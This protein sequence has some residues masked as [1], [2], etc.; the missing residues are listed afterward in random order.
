MKNGA[1]RWR[2]WLQ[3]GHKWAGFS[4][5][6]LFVLLGLTGSVL[7]FYQDLDDGFRDSGQA[8]LLVVPPDRIVAALRAAEPARDGPWRIELPDRVGAPITARY[9]NPPERAGQSF[10][11]LILRLDPDTL[12]VQTRY[13][14]GEEFWTW[15]Y[16]L[17]YSLLLGTYGTVAVGVA[18]LLTLLLLGSGLYLWWPNAGQWRGALSFKRGAVW[19][20]RVYDL[21]VKSGVYAAPF[22]LTLVITGVVLA[23]PTWF[24]PG[25]G[26][27]SPFTAV[28]GPGTIP[29]G[30]GDTLL[31]AEAAIAVARARFPQ[32]EVRWIETPGRE[33]GFWRV[34][35]RQSGEPN[36]R[37]PR[38]Q[39]WVEAVS[40]EILA[41]RDPRR[42]SIGDSIFD[43]LHPLHNGEAFGLMG[44]AV[45][46]V[47]GLLPMLAFV[48]GW[49]RWRHKRR[50]GKSV[51]AG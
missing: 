7:V 49:I 9:L 34:Q 15:I 43:W 18:G 6:A 23:V 21:H 25:I 26:W 11:P 16:K 14:W 35:M 36:R 50:A 27:F 13:F 2:S 31:S 33:Q 3:A 30:Q 48:T 28:S 29:A 41:V 45:V 44:R 5:G 39:V 22:L 40:G 17:H 37:F 4:L 12:A 10:A 1:R 8:S 32:A 46:F 51:A 38:T 47:L 20:R 24:K 42:N 19:K